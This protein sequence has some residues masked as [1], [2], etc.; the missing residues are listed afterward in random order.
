MDIQA[1]IIIAIVVVAA[2]LPR[3][4]KG[5][6]T[7][8]EQSFRCARC[9]AMAPHSARTINA[10]RDGKTKFFCS[11]CHTKWLQTQTNRRGGGSAVGGRGSGCLGIVACVLFFPV[12]LLV[13][14][15]YV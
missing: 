11:T 6:R 9:A 10:W 2:F 12:A 4:L 13:L 14:W 5:R 1:A 7:P 15:V 8:K 3:F